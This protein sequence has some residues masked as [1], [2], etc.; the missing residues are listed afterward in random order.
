[1]IHQFKEHRIPFEE[2]TFAIFSWSLCH[3]GSQ[4]LEIAGRSGLCNWRKFTASNSILCKAKYP[5]DATYTANKVTDHSEEDETG[6][7]ARE[8]FSRVT[9][10]ITS[11]NPLPTWRFKS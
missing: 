6:K 1:M 7:R 4:Y 5:L 8:F 9:P 11:S 2:Y 10:H 3:R